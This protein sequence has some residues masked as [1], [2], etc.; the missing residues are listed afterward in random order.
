VKGIV[1]NHANL[2]QEKPHLMVDFVMLCEL[3]HGVG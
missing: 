3:V 1:V 2:T